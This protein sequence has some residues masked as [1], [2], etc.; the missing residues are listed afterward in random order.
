VS[1]RRAGESTLGT[2]VEVKNLNS[3][4][5]VERALAHEIE[6]QAAVLESGGAVARETRLWDAAAGRTAPMRSKEGAHDYRYF[7]EPDLPPLVIDASRIARLRALLPE[8]PDARRDRLIATHGLSEYDATQIAASRALTC[9]FEATVGLGAKPKTVANWM[10]G[11]LAR[12][13]NASGA[14]IDVSRVGAERLAGLIGLVDAGTISV[15]VAK[16]VFER[17]WET[18]RD[19]AAIVEAEGLAQIGDEAALEAIVREVIAA[20]PKPVA[21]IR[22]GK[23]LVFGFL[24]GQVMKATRGKANPAVVNALIQRELERA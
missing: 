3:F 17:M 1:V 11:E 10:T 9:Y 22:A 20:N 13:L 21:Q 2:P 4:R 5:F 8:L 23:T 6:R 24:V 12:L 19:A 16:G 18:G 14:T 15:S 7:P